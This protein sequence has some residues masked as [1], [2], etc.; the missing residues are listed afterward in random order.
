MA[1]G[2]L[3][4]HI[5]VNGRLLAVVRRPVDWRV[6]GC[7]L[8]LGRIIAPFGVLPFDLPACHTSSVA[9]RARRR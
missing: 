6:L 4:R 9:R 2:S 3:E 1:N 5:A 7:A 8:V